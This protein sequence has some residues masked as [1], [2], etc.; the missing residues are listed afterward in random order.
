MPVELNYLAI[1][2]AAALNMVIGALWYSPLLFGGIWMRAMHYREDHLKNGPNMALLYAI[3]F[4]MV[5]L[6]NY[7]LA[8]YI[9]YFG[10]E[11]ASEGAESAF[12]PWLGFFVPVLIGSVLWERKSFK[13]FVINA[14]HYL[15]ALLC[16]GMILAIW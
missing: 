11:T 9:A 3:A 7:V 4:V 16:S 13:V 15:V 2:V 14:A 6:T 5:L 8:H 1:F 10:A 12:W